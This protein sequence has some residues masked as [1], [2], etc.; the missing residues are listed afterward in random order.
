MTNLIPI[1][2]LQIVVY[3]NENLNLHIFEPRYKQLIYDCYAANKPFGIVP[4]LQNNITEVGT[5]LTIT[6]IVQVYEDGKMDIKTQGIEVFKILEII[7]QLP[8]KLYSAAIVTYPNNNTNN[9]LHQIKQ[10]VTAVSAL[11]KILEIN[12]DFK[13]PIHELLSYDFAHHVGLSI[14]E[15]YELLQLLFEEQR[16]EFLKKHVQKV[17]S[18]VTGLESLKERIHLN[19]HFKQ[20]KGFNL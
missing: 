2:P 16:I 18:V 19:G 7:N 17:L 11:H 13:N 10:L 9:N 1:F 4:V 8:E 6:E 20:L 12:K 3:P 15:E 5:L 14:N